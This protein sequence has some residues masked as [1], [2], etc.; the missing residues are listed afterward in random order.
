[1]VLG[2]APQSGQAIS[3]TDPLSLANWACLGY[4]TGGILGPWR[5]YPKESN[6]P[7]KRALPMNKKAIPITGNIN[8]M[9]ESD[10]I[11][12]VAIMMGTTK[13]GTKNN[14]MPIIINTFPVSELPIFIVL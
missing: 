13:N 3:S 11:E 8:M 12:P 5:K 9:G 2:D 4:C 6:P 1:M 7:R 10:M 14:K